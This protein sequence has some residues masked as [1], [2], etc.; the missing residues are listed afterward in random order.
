MRIRVHQSQE[1]SPREGVPSGSA[2]D[3]QLCPHVL[4]AFCGADPTIQIEPEPF[5]K[6]I[7]HCVDLI[8]KRTTSPSV[9]QTRGMYHFP[10]SLL[11]CKM[12]PIHS[13]SNYP[14]CF[15]G[16]ITPPDSKKARWGLTEEC[17]NQ[18]QYLH[19]CSWASPVPGCPGPRPRSRCFSLRP[20]APPFD[21]GNHS[22]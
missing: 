22:D 17:S 19:H 13:F 21:C 15:A 7:T 16:M 3:G 5:T 4:L 11:C 10:D 1:S 9:R 2:A 12:Y 14:L 18:Y 20:S 8:A 6:V